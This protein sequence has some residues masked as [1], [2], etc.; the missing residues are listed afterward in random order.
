MSKFPKIQGTCPYQDSIS[1]FMDGEICKLCDRKVHNLDA[2]DESQR[3]RFLKSSKNE[4]CVSYSL[5][6][7]K[8]LAVAAIAASLSALPVAAQDEAATSLSEQHEEGALILPDIVV[9]GAIK[10]TDNVEYIDTEEDLQIPE[11]PL[12][13]ENNEG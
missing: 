11:V 8:A 1:E 7:K 9:V 6:S 2:M 13:Y 4:I 12:V 10:D 5:P 3:L